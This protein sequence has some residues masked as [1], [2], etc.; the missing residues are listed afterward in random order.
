MVKTYKE[1]ERNIPIAGSSNV[2]VCGGGPAGVSA[3]IAAARMGASTVLLENHGC[4][5]GIWTAGLLCWIIDARNKTGLMS[6][7]ME[8]LDRRGARRQSQGSDFTYDPEEMK[9]L[10]DVLCEEVGVQVQ[11]HTRVASAIVND[12]GTITGVVTESK[13]GRQ[14]WMADIVI[15]ATGDGDVAALAGCRYDMGRRENGQT[16][17]LS[18]MAMVSGLPRHA[19]PYTMNGMNEHP[20]HRLLEQIKLA[21]LTPSYSAPSL[22]QVRDDLFALMANHEY[23]VSCNNAAGITRATRQ[24]RKELHTLIDG[25]RSL[26]GDWSQLHIVGTAAQIGVRD[27]RR[28]SGLYTV[29]EKDVLGGARHH[30]SICRV[31]YGVDIHSTDPA[32]GKGFGNDGVRSLPYDIPFRALIAADV[33][34]LL[35]AGRCISGDFIAHSSYRVTGNAVAMGHA[36]GTAAALAAL[37]KRLPQQLEWLDIQRGIQKTGGIV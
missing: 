17:P 29:T 3:A 14:A 27:G 37:Y 7:I 18:L 21:G 9:Y 16:Q 5:G 11:L 31:S 26:G 32:A 23:G 8:R 22:F 10:L 28:I 12:G 25:L 33:N 15:D 6:E 4:L 35:L 34:G 30:D 24:A 19:E 2:I 36:A 20:K 1:R 13:S